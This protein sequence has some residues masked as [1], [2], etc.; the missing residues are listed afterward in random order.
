MLILADVRTQLPEELL[1]IQQK[2]DQVGEEALQLTAS[3][4]QNAV[5]GNQWV[6]TEDS[7]TT[8]KITTFLNRRVADRH[9][10]LPAHQY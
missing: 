6:K 10:R 8:I 4:P 7:K 5:K 3:I 9:G 2:R 1:R